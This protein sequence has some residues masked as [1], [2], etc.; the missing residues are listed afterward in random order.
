[1][2]VCTTEAHSESSG[3][4]GDGLFFMEN[5]VFSSSE[6]Y[7]MSKEK[8]SKKRVSGVQMPSKS[9]L[10]AHKP[11]TGAGTL[12]V[13]SKAEREKLFGDMQ[14]GVSISMPPK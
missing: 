12:P 7:P 1:M 10:K 8:P 9:S 11:L 14:G 6:D 4:F 2:Q 13:M 3:S 5:P